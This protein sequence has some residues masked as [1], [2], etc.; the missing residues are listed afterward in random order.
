MI[1]ICYIHVPNDQAHE[2]M[3]MNYIESMLRNPPGTDHRHL[4]IC[5]NRHVRHHMH[6]QF[7]RMGD[8][9]Y[10]RHDDTGW[11][12]GGYIAAAKH[13]PNEILMCMGG[14]TTVRNAS[15]LN[16]IREAWN[17]HGPGMYG[18]LTSNQIRPH[19]NSTGFLCSAQMLLSYPNTVITGPDRYEFEH[20]KGS[21]WW[22]LNQQGFPTKLVT[23]CGEY[24]WPDWRK[25]PNISCRGDQSNCLTWFRINYNYE[26][27]CKHDGGAKERLEFLTDHHVVDTDFK[28]PNWVLP[29]EAPA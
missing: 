23:W 24:D 19:F 17:K 28:Y 16:R 15:W 5:Q 14:S 27:Y 9:Q 25:P 29:N 20:G 1:V 7:V 22:R 26:H 13:L 12:I 10:I 18:T 11:D 3:A 6:K 2:P 21:F 8:V 4:I